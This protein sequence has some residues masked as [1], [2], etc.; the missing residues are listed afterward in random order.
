[1][2]LMHGFVLLA[3]V[4]SVVG[5]FS[6]ACWLYVKYVDWICKHPRLTIALLYLLIAI[7]VFMIGAHDG[8]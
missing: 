2:N 1:M 3:L 4:T 6:G 7:M 5:M 8:L